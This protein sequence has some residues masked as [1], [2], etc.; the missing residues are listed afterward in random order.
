MDQICVLWPEG[1][2]I[3]S[4]IITAQ[5]TVVLCS[6]VLAII[7]SGCGTLSDRSICGNGVCETLVE[8]SA[9]CSLDCGGAQTPKAVET[10]QDEQEKS[11]LF[12]ADQITGAV[13]SVSTNSD[14][15]NRH[16]IPQGFIAYW[17]FDENVWRGT[18][19]EV[20]DTANTYHGTAISGA[21]TAASASGRLGSFDGNSYVSAP[22]I[23][24]PS[25][26]PTSLP[27][28]TIGFWVKPDRTGLSPRVSFAGFLELGNPSAAKYLIFTDG[29]M[30]YTTTRY[31]TAGTVMGSFKAT[32]LP[33]ENQQNGWVH[34]AITYYGRGVAGIYINGSPAKLEYIRETSPGYP[35][36]PWNNTST[37]T[38]V[39]F[40]PSIP[41][42]KKYKGLMDEPIVYNRI[43]KDTEIS[44]LY[45]A[46]KP[47]FTTGELPLAPLKICI[48]HDFG[49]DYYTKGYI[50]TL[51]GSSG[52]I[53]GIEDVCASSST[54]KEY[55]CSNGTAVLT[56]Y[57]CPR[58]CMKGACKTAPASTDDPQCFVELT[59]NETFASG[60]TSFSLA[61]IKSRYGSHNTVRP[62]DPGI[63]DYSLRVYG[64]AGGTQPELLG[65]YSLNDATLMVIDD[66]GAVERLP[67]GTTT[68]TIPYDRRITGIKAFDRTAST[69]LG[70]SISGV[71]CGRTCKLENETGEFSRQVG[72]G[73]YESDECCPGQGLIPV[74]NNFSNTS[75]F[76]CVK[77]GN[78]TCGNYENTISCPLDCR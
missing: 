19:Q 60:K 55:S 33:D 15:N 72:G 7:L 78:G 56:Q 17:K 69:D 77:C 25:T 43:L 22:P 8:S 75:T 58:G 49:V 38:S 52:A 5:K 68:V 67:S 74:Y 30:V 51:T 14:I 36:I 66:I 62:L 47:K 40:G 42:A 9:T 71:T 63:S 31:T 27:N 12:P 44:E 76:V 28:T 23:S 61:G 24:V 39:A 34:V 2:A 10:T 21:L 35:Q 59:I 41:T 26:V 1:C 37:A 64:N 54:L 45:L 20:R 13:V 70:F 53:T 16:Y 3:K 4:E 6:I 46:Q 57:V 11:K 29:N 48:D 65:Q 18:T 73:A 32:G 50:E